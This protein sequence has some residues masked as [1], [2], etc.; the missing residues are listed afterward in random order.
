MGPSVSFLSHPF[1]LVCGDPHSSLL[2]WS[3]VA[4]AENRRGSKAG[5]GK[6]LSPEDRVSTRGEAQD[7]AGPAD[8]VGGTMQRVCF[9]AP[10]QSVLSAGTTPISR[11][12]PWAS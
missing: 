10:R 8:V 6:G 5:W 3:V 4:V 12:K 9:Q 1:L 2:F 11:K 7:G